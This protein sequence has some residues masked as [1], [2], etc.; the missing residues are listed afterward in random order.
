MILAEHTWVPVLPQWM[1]ELQPIL[2]VLGLFAG[3][4]VLWQMVLT[5]FEPRK[6]WKQFRSKEEEE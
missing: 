1:V 5:T 4:L 2:V 6:R 3:V